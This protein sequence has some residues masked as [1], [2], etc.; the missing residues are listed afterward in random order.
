LNLDFCTD[1]CFVPVQFTNI[2][3]IFNWGDIIMV[4]SIIFTTTQDYLLT[5]DFYIEDEPKCSYSLSRVLEVLKKLVSKIIVT[6]PE[7][8]CIGVFGF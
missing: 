1:I 7:S 2:N 6:V 5:T 4:D 3:F 8:L